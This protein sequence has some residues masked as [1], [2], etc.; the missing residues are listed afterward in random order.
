MVSKSSPE[1]TS[2]VTPEKFGKSTP[3]SF[4]EYVEQ[5]GEHFNGGRQRII[6]VW[7]GNIVKAERIGYE[8]FVEEPRKSE[9]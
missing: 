9:K 6:D 7:K 4:L 8:D 3:M 5:H 1:G 2:P